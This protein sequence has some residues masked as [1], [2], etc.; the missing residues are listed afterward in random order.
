MRQIKDT[1]YLHIS[2]RIRSKEQE[3]L[4]RVSL[5]RVIDAASDEDAVKA[6]TLRGWIDFDAHDLNSLERAISKRREEI[7]EFLYANCPDRAIIEIF[8]LQYDYHNLKAIIKGRA[9][10]IDCTGIL[11][12]AG[13]I[14]PRKMQDILRDGDYAELSPI[15]AS[16]IVEAN[17]VLSRTGDPQLSDILLD[18]ALAAQIHELSQNAAS[19]FLHVYVRLMLDCNNLKAAARIARMGRGLDYLTRTI[20]PGG[21]ASPEKFFGGD[22]ADLAALFAHSLLEHAAELALGAINGENSFA[23]LDISCD[24]ALISCLKD[25]KTVPFGEATVIAYLLANEAEFVAVRTV[26]Y[27]RDAGLSPEEIAE[28]LRASYV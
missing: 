15:M 27:G 5:M 19:E 2:A 21:N 22:A 9:Q 25:A 3:M 26:F 28:R 17:D 10:N 11:S 23:A 4:D 20:C 13:L 1:E 8:R 6:M 14:A 12:A 7:M 18:R 24:N 16:A